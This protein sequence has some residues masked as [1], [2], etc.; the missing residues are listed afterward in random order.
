MS[1]PFRVGFECCRTA[2]AVRVDRSSDMPAAL[3][4]LGLHGPRQVVV[5][6]GGASGLDAGDLDKLCPLFERALVPVAERFGAF[7][8]DGGTDAG[9]MHLVGQ[10][11]SRA[12]ATFLLVGVAAAGTVSLVS[13]RPLSA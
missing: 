9:V 8:V 11:R 10:A 6:V 12:S 2:V 7:V 13:G 3:G 1:A 5:L 4:A